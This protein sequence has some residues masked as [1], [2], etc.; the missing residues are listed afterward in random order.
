MLGERTVSKGSICYGCN[1]FK[2]EELYSDSVANTPRIRV[3]SPGIRG[4]C[5]A[6]ETYHKHTDTRPENFNKS[7]K[8]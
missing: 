8:K 4:V 5:T 1:F 3:P 6:P 7:M 2:P